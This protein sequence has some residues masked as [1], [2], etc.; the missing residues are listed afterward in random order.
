MRFLIYG[1]EC[2]AVLRFLIYSNV[3]KVIRYRK[4]F[5]FC[6]AQFGFFVHS[7]FWLP[8]RSFNND[9]I[10]FLMLRI[11]WNCMCTRCLHY[12]DLF[13]NVTNGFISHCLRGVT[14][15]HTRT[16]VHRKE[17]R[18]VATGADR[19]IINFSID[20]TPRI[21]TTTMC[22]KHIVG[23]MRREKYII[24]KGLRRLDI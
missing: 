2:K 11:S 14:Y 17:L 7:Y 5:F 22:L 15:K 16:Y 3:F 24:E 9:I 18:R 8:L 20:A 1:K 12:E 23:D 4:H 13:V 19:R 10:L 21:D 6:S